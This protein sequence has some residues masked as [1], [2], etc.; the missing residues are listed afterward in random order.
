M[1]KYLQFYLLFVILTAG[2]YSQ[3]YQQRFGSIPVTIN[4]TQS[5]NPFN[6]GIDAP[7][8]QMIDIDGDNDLDLFLYDKDTSLFYYR[9][10]GSQSSP[11]FTLVTKRFLNLLI[12]N[13]Y[14][15]AD[16]DSDGD[17]DL[18][19][20]G[21]NQTIQLFKN[22]GTITNPAFTLFSSEL[23]T[24]TDSTIFS[25]SVC[26]PTFAD[27]DADGDLDFFTG[28]SVGRVSYY[29]NIGT[30]QSFSF[31]FITHFF[32]NI[33]IIGGGNPGAN[34]ELHGA[35]SLFFTDINNDN[36]QD[37]FW[38]DYFGNS[39]YFLRNNGTPQVPNITL[40]DSSYP[41]PSQWFSLGYNVPRFYDIDNDGRKDFF[42]GVVYG[43]Q[44]KS[45]FVYYKNNGP[46]NAPQFTKMTEN[47]IPCIDAGANGYPS[48]CDIDNDGDMDLFL[49]SDHATVSYYRNSGTGTN[50][51]FELVTDS[52]P[53]IKTSFNYAEC[54][55]DLDNDGR[56]DMLIGA[57]DGK[58][59]YLKNTGTLQ[60]PVFTLQPSQLDTIDVGQSSA[61][62]LVD[63][64]ND[65]DL[66]LFIGNW[67]GRI[68]Y[69][70]N[71]G[72]LSSFSYSF[73]SS[74]YLNIDVGDE[75]NLAFTDIDND[76]DFDMFIG[77]RDGRIT[78]YRNSGNASGPNFVFVTDDYA[79]VNVSSNSVPAFADINSDS[80]KDLFV[81]CIKGGIYFYENLDVIGV[82]QTSNNI[83]RQFILYQN[84]PNP[85]NPS[86][87]L[88]LD[89]PANSKGQTSDVKLII[90]DVSGRA[91]STLLNSS[92]TPGTYEIDWNASNYSS[93]LYFY[94]N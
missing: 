69:Y 3:N 1:M 30:P 8:F 32:Q 46:A 67:N 86:T 78:F 80:D 11:S 42:I 73:V 56:K 27:I 85:F 9:N 90:Y 68:S 4:G 58:L 36:T 29:Q 70:K 47:F 54:F 53:I 91:V 77:R 45:N 92:L 51:A 59:R 21:S 20:G 74:F 10:D 88:K 48:F 65:G 94:T 41:H 14:Y 39:V 12:T 28:S 19:T 33:E 89:I 52:I 76:G 55:G 18:F 24:N 16:I 44:T 34:I 43:S 50:P 15:F 79:S 37:L 72:N 26:I 23:K 31:K 75:S 49:G 38:G 63:I 57:F 35:S 61:P 64:D 62:Q 25:E 71:D 81:G 87:K 13:W 66:D 22:T 82:Q 7:R 40:T 6:G 84:Y 83:P 17:Y 5:V 93:G 2:L 60:S